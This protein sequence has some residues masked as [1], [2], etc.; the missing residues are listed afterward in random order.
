MDRLIFNQIDFNRT[1]LS[2]AQRQAARRAKT[3]SDPRPADDYRG[4][5]R[6]ARAQRKHPS[7]GEGYLGPI[8]LNRSARWKHAE[9][10]FDARDLSPS[11]R[12]VV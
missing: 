9:N 5:K 12:E 4:A 11:N 10:Y 6:N 1:P 8:K 7:M 3:K 2:A